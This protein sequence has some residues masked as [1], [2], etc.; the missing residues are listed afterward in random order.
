M[1]A[2]IEVLASER[3]ETGSVRRGFVAMMPLWV[4][5]IP[6]GATFAILARGS[7]F[8]ALETQA[9]SMLVF[10]GS[11]QLTVVTLVV[12]GAGL[13]AVVLTTAL[14]NLRHLLYAVSLARYLGPHVRPP[15][16]LLA[17]FLTD[18]SFGVTI[19]AFLQGRGSAGFL[20]GASFSLYVS[21]AG[22]TA[23]GSFLGTHIPAP[24]R[25]GLDFIFPLSFLA[26]LLPL[27]HGWRQVAVAVLAAV[28]ALWFGRILDG[29]L[30]VLLATSAAAA[31]GVLIDRRR[32][33]R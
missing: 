26:L 1:A 31:A 2:E 7:G 3:A 29:G 19:R 27:L 24:E 6:F 21:F 32:D 8:S 30:T 11:A 25:I 13:P 12:A 15:R 22:A 16:W 5:V 28:L 9:L 18:E 23:A 33:G 10:A 17:F 4:G 14:L 20:F